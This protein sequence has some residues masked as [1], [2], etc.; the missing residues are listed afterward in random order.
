MKNKYVSQLSNCFRQQANLEIASQQQA[1]MKGKFEYFGLK[2]P[3]R[4]ELQKPFLLKSSLPDINELTPTIKELWTQP[5]RECQYFAQELLFKYH[6]Q[7]EVRELVLM[8]FMVTEKSWWDT[9]DFI[10]SNCMGRYFML[11]P[12]QTKNVTRRWMDTGNM[13]LQRSALLFQLKYKN[14]LDTDLLE[15]YIPK[16]LGSKEFYINKAIG[17]A[18]RQHSKTDPNWVLEFA[19]RTDLAPLSRKEALRLIA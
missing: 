1:Y 11:H 7:F 8:E 14:H 4:K 16:L 19:A 6:R 12:E 18:L 13:W 9:V 5:Q 3:V 10:A 17:W 2:S 15:E